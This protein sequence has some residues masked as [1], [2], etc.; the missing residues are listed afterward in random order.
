MAGGFCVAP[1][2]K[3][4]LSSK[5]VPWMLGVSANAGGGRQAM[6]A[7]VSNS[8]RVGFNAAIPFVGGGCVVSGGAGCRHTLIPCRYEPVKIRILLVR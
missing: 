7:T 5:Y 1:P 2:G 3:S 6:A 8:M 4:R